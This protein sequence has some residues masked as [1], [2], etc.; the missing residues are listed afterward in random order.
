MTEKDIIIGQK[1]TNSEFPGVTYLGIGRVKQERE[2]KKA[3]IIID[4]Y[5][6]NFIGRRFWT[7]KEDPSLVRIWNSFSP[8]AP[9]KRK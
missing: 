2:S 4:S 9:R 1:Y 7:I 3:L 5:L 8:A 6:P